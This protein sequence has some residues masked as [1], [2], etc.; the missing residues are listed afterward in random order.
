MTKGEVIFA[1]LMLI[2]LI[3]MI[4]IGW[5]LHCAV[6]RLENHKSI[7]EVMRDYENQE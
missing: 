3:P 1:V 6:N 5:T 4:W 2:Q 7:A